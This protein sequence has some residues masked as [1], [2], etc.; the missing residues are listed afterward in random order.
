MEVFYRIYP[1][2]E[3]GNAERPFFPNDKLAL[4]YVCLMSFVQSC[5]FATKSPRLTF[6]LDGCQESWREMVKYVASLWDFR[7]VRILTLDGVG[8]QPSFRFQLDLAP[9]SAEDIIYFAEDDYLYGQMAAQEMYRFAEQSDQFWTPYDHPD[10]YTRDD[11]RDG[12]DTRI[13][14]VGDWQRLADK[15]WRHQGC[16]WRRVESACM[17]FGGQKRLFLENSELIREKACTG[18]D[19][20]YPL[21]D[22]GYVLWSAIPALATHVRDAYLSMCVD[23]RGVVRDVLNR[24]LDCLYEQQPMSVLMEL[25]ML[26]LKRWR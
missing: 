19:L 20:W 24:Q 15:T 2:E 9:E 6:I 8:N 3:K 23:W 4:T 1:G 7:D 25:L 11:D 22:E 18:R 13:Q 14:V 17:T 10:R 16:H 5:A 26:E 12:R 21:L